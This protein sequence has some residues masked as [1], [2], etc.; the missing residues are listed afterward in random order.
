MNRR[1]FFKFL[2]LAPLVV[3]SEAKAMAHA[4][5]APDTTINTFLLSNHKKV[6]PEDIPAWPNISHNTYFGA[7]NGEVAMKTHVTA[8]IAVGN[9]GCLWTKS[10]NGKW[11]RVVTE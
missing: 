7:P 11:K 10:Q 4:D 1:D 5:D 3:V 6:N 2:P 8:A 9:D